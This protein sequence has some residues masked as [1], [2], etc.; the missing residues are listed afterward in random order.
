MKSIQGAGLIGD[1][2][3]PT[4]HA[5]G[6]STP[7]DM[8]STMIRFL[9]KA[10]LKNGAYVPAATAF[11]MELTGYMR[12]EYDIDIKFGIEMFGDTAIHWQLDVPDLATLEELNGK[13]MK[14]KDYWDML[15]K[16]K[17]FW[18]DGSLKDVVVNFPDM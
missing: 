11:S 4:I 8:E 14:N 1:G 13:L 12:K 18:V 7:I 17:E 10:Q 5:G 15:E 2:R 16:A 6:V 9:R 3:L